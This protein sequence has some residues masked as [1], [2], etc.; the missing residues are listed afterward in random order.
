MNV[1]V[2]LRPGRPA[3]WS[4]CEGRRARR[5]MGR[6]RG[7]ATPSVA[8]PREESRSLLPTAAMLRNGGP[9]I[10]RFFVISIAKLI[11]SSMTDGI[12]LNC[13]GRV[14]QVNHHLRGVPWL[15][16]VRLSQFFRDAGGALTAPR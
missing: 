15:T 9:S 12:R 4:G 1:G 6:E 10:R 2:V 8:R 3:H 5:S 13:D 7:A 11:A 14:V 16:L